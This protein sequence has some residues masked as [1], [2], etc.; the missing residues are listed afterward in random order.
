MT[1]KLDFK[2]IERDISVDQ[3]VSQTAMGHKNPKTIEEHGR[4]RI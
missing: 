1:K 4:M 2:D 3:I